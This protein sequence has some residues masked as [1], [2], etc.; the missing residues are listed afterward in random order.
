MKFKCVSFTLYI[1]KRDTSVVIFDCDNI[2]SMHMTFVGEI[3][4]RYTHSGSLFFEIG[5]KNFYNIHCYS[6]PFL[7]YKN[8]EYNRTTDNKYR[9]SERDNSVM[10]KE[11][12]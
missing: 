3:L 4:L 6:T 11:E 10:E 8:Y 7:Y 5:T 2:S 1:F 12:V 9:Y